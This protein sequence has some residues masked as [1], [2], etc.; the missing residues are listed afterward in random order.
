[1]LAGRGKNY[2][3]RTDSRLYGHARK[4]SPSFVRVFQQQNEPVYAWRKK[5]HQ[6]MKVERLQRKEHI[7]LK[8]IEDGIVLGK[9][10]ALKEKEQK[11]NELL[12]SSKSQKAIS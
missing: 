4:N 11:L 7:R 12:E 3:G 9:W 2:L 10:R 6:K 8:R 1:M 5:I